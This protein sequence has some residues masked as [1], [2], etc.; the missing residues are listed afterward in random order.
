MAGDEMD[1]MAEDMRVYGSSKGPEDPVAFVKDEAAPS[2]GGGGLKNAIDKVLIADFFFILFILAWL[3]VGVGEKSLLQS[4]RLL[5]A[6]Y[7][8]WQWVFQPALGVLMLGALVSGAAGKLGEG[9]DKQQA[10]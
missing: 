4:S 3:G 1:L 9:R 5:D 10:R 8:L 7:P 6:W 2:G